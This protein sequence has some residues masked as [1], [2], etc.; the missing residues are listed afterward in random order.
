MQIIRQMKTFANRY[1]AEWNAASLAYTLELKRLVDAYR[2]N[3]SR[4]WKE[5]TL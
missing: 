5:G 4:F 3:L 1:K 2:M